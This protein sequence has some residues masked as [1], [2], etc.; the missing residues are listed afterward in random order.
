M[1]GLLRSLSD[2]CRMSWLYDAY[3]W[4]KA[5]HIVAAIAWMAGL[6]YLPRLFVYHLDTRIGAEDSE[7][8]KVMEQRLLRTIMGPAMIATFLPGAILL[9][10]SPQLDWAAGWLWVKLAG[11]VALAVLHGLFASWA[12]ELAENRRNRSGRCYRIANEAPALVMAVM[13]VAV[14]AKPF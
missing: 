14:V 3:P 11:V 2:G 10:V 1:P 4:V 8:F 13:V 7:R 5:I 12:R 6:L 9:L